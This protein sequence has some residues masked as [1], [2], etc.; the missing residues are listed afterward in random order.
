MEKVMSEDND[1]IISSLFRRMKKLNPRQRCVVYKSLELPCRVQQFAEMDKDKAL[2]E[3][4]EHYR[5]LIKDFSADAPSVLFSLE[6][7]I[8]DA[9]DE[10]VL[11]PCMEELKKEV[12][13]LSEEERRGL[14]YDSFDWQLFQKQFWDLESLQK[15]AKEML[16]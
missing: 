13:S 6:K 10:K 9:A 3:F 1:R 15:R 4:F 12:E 2:V 5:S 16:E 11:E 8:I 7:A 14:G